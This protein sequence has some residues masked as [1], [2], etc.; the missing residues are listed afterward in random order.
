MPMIDVYK[1]QGRY[2][3]RDTNGYFRNIGGRYIYLSDDAIDSDSLSDIKLLTDQILLGTNGT[4][5]VAIGKSDSTEKEE[6]YEELKKKS[7]EL[8]MNNVFFLEEDAETAARLK[9]AIAEKMKAGDLLVFR[10]DFKTNVSLLCDAVFGTSISKE[11]ELYS[12]E[13]INC[14][15]VMSQVIPQ[16]GEG[17][18]ISVEQEKVAENVKIPEEIDGIPIY[19]LGKHVFKDNNTITTV[20]FGKKLK[21]IGVG[22]FYNCQKLKELLIPSNVKM[23][24]SGAFRNCK[25][26]RK[27]MIENG[28]IHISNNVFR[29]CENL[30]DIYLPYSIGYIGENAFREC[31]DIK[32]HCYE[33]SLPYI[34]AKDQGLNIEV[35]TE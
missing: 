6:I 8:N 17:E 12:P 13:R 11:L 31:Y 26:L 10:G 20:A 33:H 15:G 29:G 18:I 35:L 28:V 3:G 4:S 2:R 22:S 9:Y 32:I 27:V 30:T 24:D 16:L 1:R 14:D 34:Y 7:L 21:S 19:K 25:S 5:F 23:I